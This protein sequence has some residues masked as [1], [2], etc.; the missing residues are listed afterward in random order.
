VAWPE[1]KNIWVVVLTTI[2]PKYM[3]GGMTGIMSG[4][5]PDAGLTPRLVFKQEKVLHKYKK[6][7]ELNKRYKTNLLF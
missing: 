7:I 2:R 5:V 4:I 6:K 3:G 1:E